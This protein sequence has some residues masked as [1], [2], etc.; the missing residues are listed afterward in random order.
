MRIA[1]AILFAIG[2]SAQSPVVNP[3]PR[4]LVPGGTCGG[5]LGGRYP[6]CTIP[7]AW[8][9]NNVH[10]NDGATLTG[11]FTFDASTATYTHVSLTT[12]GGSRVPNSSAWTVSPSIDNQTL[13][14]VI[15]GSHGSTPSDL[16][17]A[18]VIYL[19][20]NSSLTN[21]PDVVVDIQVSFDGFGSYGFCLDALCSFLNP[22]TPETDLAPGV[23]N[24]FGAGNLTTSPPLTSYL[25]ML[26]VSGE[27]EN[28]KQ[29]LLK[30][31]AATATG[32]P[33][34]LGLGDSVML[35]TTKTPA[36]SYLGLIK[37]RL[38]SRFT[39]LGEGFMSWQYSIHGNF[40]STGSWTAQPGWGITNPTTGT[41][42]NPV[43]KN[44][45]SGTITV[46]CAACDTF[47]VSYLTNTDTSAG[48]TSTLDG[49]SPATHGNTT[50]AS[51]TWATQTI[52]G[53]SPGA[54]SL[55]IT[56]PSSGNAYIFG[57]YAYLNSTGLLVSNMGVSGTYIDEYFGLTDAETYK[58]VGWLPLVSPAPTL[59]IVAL[60]EN[61]VD[62]GATAAHPDLWGDYLNAAL[63]WLHRKVPSA[64]LMVLDPFVFGGDYTAGDQASILPFNAY[65]RFVAV[66]N[67]VGYLNI[68]DHWGNEPA[69]FA[70]GLVEDDTRHPTDAGHYDYSEMLLS[71][72]FRDSW[73]PGFT[74]SK[75]A[76]SCTFT[77]KGGLITAVSGC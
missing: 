75:V 5:V 22:T 52:A 72:L 76:G 28:P 57:V 35:Q 21:T 60:L 62:L 26:R 3:Y 49:G 34:I 40:A 38:A 16:T 1:I 15:V 58:H 20:A 61:S 6:A 32:S 65:S 46:T 9:I 48:W 39:D 25:G 14:F 73:L 68:G 13:L 2:V 56:A 54:H 30:H 31:F 55:V 59:L 50:S 8:T 41:A 77:I 63:N 53:G 64:S 11:G 7:L 18:D 66:A 69:A 19:G 43:L 44:G 74:G 12:A 71:Y 36:E 17:G 67:N 51:L 47:K 29:Q 23:S 4:P 27:I 70:V 10:F 24:Y 37:S 33:V 45:A 42:H